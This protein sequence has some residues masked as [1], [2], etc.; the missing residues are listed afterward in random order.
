MKMP[1]D[2]FTGYPFILGRKTKVN[3]YHNTKTRIGDMVFDSR[4]EANR[5]QEL[6]L[7][8]RGG[9][10]VPLLYEYTAKI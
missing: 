1:F 5:F 6:L 3:K 8:E 7:L 10:G 2:D 9:V 4:K